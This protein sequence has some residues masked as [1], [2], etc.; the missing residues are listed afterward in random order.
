MRWAIFLLVLVITAS[1]C[2]SVDSLAK[3]RINFVSYS[4]ANLVPKPKDASIDLFFQGTPKK[5]YIVI[6]E[7]MGNVDNGDQVR[8]YLEARARQVGADAVINIETSQGSKIGSEIEDVPVSGPR[9]YVRE[10][11]VQ[12]TYSYNIVNIKGKA[13][14]YK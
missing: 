4:D 14:R 6:G 13:I 2:V 8:P 7:F 10:V 1:G 3:N 9:G 11:P 5:D 12:Q